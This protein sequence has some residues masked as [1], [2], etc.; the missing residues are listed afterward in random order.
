MVARIFRPAKT[1]MQSGRG[2]ADH[3]ILIHD[4]DAAGPIEPLM[5]YTAGTDMDQQV[6][7][8]FATREDAVAYAERRGLAYEVDA[9]HERA[10]K[11]ISYAENFS[12]A[13]P[14]PWTH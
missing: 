9:E 6:R 7:L 5:G 12:A 13:R 3:W 11:A 14:L 10:P 1:A 2:K 8:A 4:A